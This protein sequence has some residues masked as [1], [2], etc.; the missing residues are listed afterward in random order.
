MRY[1]FVV[2]ATFFAAFGWWVLPT[3]IDQ[4]TARSVVRWL[5]AFIVAGLLFVYLKGFEGIL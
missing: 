4:A 3:L 5:T 1:P 2:L